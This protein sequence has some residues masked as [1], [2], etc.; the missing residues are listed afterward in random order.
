MKEL[1]YK[2]MKKIILLLTIAVLATSCDDFLQQDPIDQLGEGSFYTNDDEID[3]ATIACYNGLQATMS[4]EWL[5]TEV[6]TDNSRIHSRSTTSTT[7]KNVISV[8]HL[9]VPTTHIHNEQYWEA[10]YHNI[11]RCNT[12]LENL[13]VVQDSALKV[14]FEAEARFIRGYHY[15]N[16]VRL[17]GPVFKVDSRLSIP[18][19]NTAERA[20]VEEIY[21]FIQ[22]DLDFAQ[23]GLPTSYDDDEAGRVTAWAAKTLLAKVFLTLEDY[24]AAETLLDEVEGSGFKLLDNYADVFDYNNEMN[25]EILFAV[26]F[27]TGG[28]GLGSPF[29][30]FFAPNGSQDAVIA[31]SG[32]GY[33]CPSTSLIQ[34]YEPAD[35]IRKNVTLSADY[36]NLSGDVAPMA[37]VKKYF[38]D[39]SIRYDAENDWPVIRYADVL[40]MQAEVKLENSG[41]AAALPYINQTRVRA[42]LDPLT[43]VEVP[44]ILSAQLAIEDERRFEFAMENHRFYDLIRT[45]RFKTIMDVHFEEE[46]IQTTD[47]TLDPAYTDPDYAIYMPNRIVEEWQ[48]LLPIP[49]SVTSV[50]PQVAQNVGY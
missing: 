45:N 34:A 30:N 49:F 48:L 33:N 41:V 7:S 42:K 6:R 39:V 18:D 43:T 50:S 10:V 12:V 46:L 31:F 25:E 35:T 3:M 8:D 21:D 36:I 2:M 4:Y 28:Y 5:L 23:K 26:R 14:Q 32:E 24:D 44:D 9:T 29:A 17:Y 37:W 11:Y 47:G 16:L 1:N 15:F 22:E 38:F 19:A 20:P 27:K 40:L 13:G